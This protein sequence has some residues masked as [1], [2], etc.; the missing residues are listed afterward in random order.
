MDGYAVYKFETHLHT[1]EVSPCA[2]IPAQEMV[3]LYRD[4]GYSGL[5]VTDHLYPPNLELFG[6][7]G[8]HATMERF[9][10]GYRLAK[11]E[12]DRIGVD[13]LLGAELL[14]DGGNNEYLLFGLTEEFLYRHENIC[15]YDLVRLREACTDA[16]VL[17]YQAH[18]YRPE[19]TRGLPGF[20]D[21]VEVYNGCPRHGSRNELALAYAER[22]RLGMS[23]GS[24]AHQYEDVGRGGIMTET[25]ITDL[26]SLCEALSG[27]YAGIIRAEEDQPKPEKKWK[28]PF[29]RKK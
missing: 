21:G 29:S 10:L 19:M 2:R 25:R 1:S 13:V 26:K 16:G 17:I 5:L 24:D 11:E 6:C 18:P 7:D 14:P 28:W 12:G 4:A 23:S 3:R 20:L 15:R 8:W 27:G 9:M 22:N